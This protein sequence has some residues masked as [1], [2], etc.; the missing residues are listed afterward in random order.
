MMNK[1]VVLIIFFGANLSAQLGFEKLEENQFIKVEN[2]ELAKKELHN[3]NI[4]IQDPDEIWVYKSIL[5]RWNRFNIIYNMKPKDGEILYRFFEEAVAYDSN[6][7]CKTYTRLF[8]EKLKDVEW[9]AD[10]YNHTVKTMDSICRS[11]MDYDTLSMNILREV[12]IDDQRYRKEIAS[13]SESQKQQLIDSVNLLKIIK[14]IDGKGYP[15]IEQVGQELSEVAWKVILRSNIETV[16]KYF[17]I[18]EE[19]VEERNIFPRAFAFFEDRINVEK[20][21]PQRFGTQSYLNTESETLVLYKIED[22]KNLMKLRYEYMVSGDVDG[23]DEY[24]PVL[25][26]K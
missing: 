26:G 17:P 5:H 6:T 24:R 15:G 8:S 22:P 20:G 4:A 3:Y 1:L 9:A 10:Y 19:G 2:F 11:V 18:I 16:I 21:L 25:D 23:Y 7:F 12:E 13:N 14:I